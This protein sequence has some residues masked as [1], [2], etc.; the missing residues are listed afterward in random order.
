MSMQVSRGDIMSFYKCVKCGFIT[1]LAIPQEQ[2][3]NEYSEINLNCKNHPCNSRLYK[4]DHEQHLK[5][6]E[7][8]K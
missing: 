2:A 3:Q 7:S 1:N 8:Q 4:Y 5:F 6:L